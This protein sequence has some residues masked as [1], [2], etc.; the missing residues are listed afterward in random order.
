MKNFRHLTGC[1]NSS[2]F[3]NKQSLNLV[4]SSVQ[5]FSTVLN[6][7]ESI[8]NSFEKSNKKKIKNRNKF[9]VEAKNYV[10]NFLRLYAK[11]LKNVKG[12]W[13][14]KYIFITKY[15]FTISLKQI[16]VFLIG[17]AFCYNVSWIIFQ[18]CKSFSAKDEERQCQCESKFLSW[19]LKVNF[20]EKKTK[21]KFGQVIFL[22]RVLGMIFP[23]AI[24]L[25]PFAFVK[26]R[27]G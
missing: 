8:L 13:Q 12:I 15:K 17:K 19:E 2:C 16:C 14:Q 4:N 6:I 21:M 23:K 22:I 20:G 3:S 18:F 1:A 9:L 5:N 24:C 7:W 25:F 27:A 26:Y 10:I 11:E